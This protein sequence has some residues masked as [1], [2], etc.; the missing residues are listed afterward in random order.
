MDLL[1]I[2]GHNTDKPTRRGPYRVTNE[3]AVLAH[4]HRWLSHNFFFLFFWEGGGLTFYFVKVCAPSFLITRH[5]ITS[6]F[7]FSFFSLAPVLF[8]CFLLY[9]FLCLM[10][11]VFVSCRQWCRH[12]QTKRFHT[13]H[14]KKYQT[15]ITFPFLKNKIN[16]VGR[17]E[18]KEGNNIKH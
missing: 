14:K 12:T 7:Y 4:I 11:F 2:F 15:I 13:A 17:L 9:S 16:E 8:C 3:F 6:F 18:R 10:H 1:I 5:Y